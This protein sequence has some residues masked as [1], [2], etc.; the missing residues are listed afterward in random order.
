MQ[1][2]ALNIQDRLHTI[3]V[4]DRTMEAIDRAV[5]VYEDQKAPQLMLTLYPWV[6]AAHLADD[7]VSPND[8]LCYAAVH[9][10]NRIFGKRHTDPRPDSKRPALRVSEW[11]DICRDIL[12]GLQSIVATRVMETHDTSEV[13][14]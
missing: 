14:P 3:S 13:T 9:E 2:I 7:P 12:I 1:S 5:N 6:P 11:R 10:T 8:Y 4:T